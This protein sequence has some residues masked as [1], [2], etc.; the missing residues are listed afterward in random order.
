MNKSYVAR[1]AFGFIAVVATSAQAA[2]CQSCRQ[3]KAEFSGGKVFLATR[4]NNSR[5]FWFVLDS[6]VRNV[7]VATSISSEI[8]LKYTSD[9][10]YSFSFSISGFQFLVDGKLPVGDLGYI[11]APNRH[12]LDGLVGGELLQNFVVQIDYGKGD[13]IFCPHESLPAGDLGPE[14]KIEIGQGG[15]PAVVTAV[16]ESLH[17]EKI[18]VRLEVD[19]GSDAAVTLFA[20]FVARHP[21]LRSPRD[22]QLPTVGVGGSRNVTLARLKDIRVSL[23]TLRDMIV[24]LEPPAETDAQRTTDGLLGKEFL[25][26]FTVT[27]DY[28]SNRIF[29]NPNGQYRE[30]PYDYPGVWF[31]P[32][33]KTKRIVAV[34]LAPNSPAGAAGI[35]VGDELVSVDGVPVA[36]YWEYQLQE[37]W[38]GYGKTRRLVLR[39]GSETLN[40]DLKLRKWF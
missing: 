7:A 37:L 30:P 4:I 8:P 39:R 11:Q 10:G 22:P 18:T 27:L 1:L 38:R 26:R 25:R 6:G 33:E 24:N 12:E 40:V 16:L 23:F 15:F 3:V 19:I 2:F 28:P 21:E 14:V 29:L 36:G 17:R 5:E 20:P 13:V 31:T 9:A 34:L 35:R 32:D